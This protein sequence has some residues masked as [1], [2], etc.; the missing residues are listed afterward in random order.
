[1]ESSASTKGLLEKYYDDLSS[2]RNW[3]SLLSDDFLFTGTVAKESRGREPYVNN[4]FFKRVR[5]LQVKEMI[6]EGASGFAIINYDLVS[7][8]GKPFSS[9]VAEFWKAKE[10]RLES[11]AIYFDTAA[12]S[13]FMSQ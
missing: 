3:G 1:M 8:G 9:D 5:S 6:T 4:G 11:V 12:F 10:G 2:K 7:P 13:K